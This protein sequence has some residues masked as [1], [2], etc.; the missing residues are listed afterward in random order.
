MEVM[1]A[2][3]TSQSLLKHELIHYFFLPFRSDSA[4]QFNLND[5]KKVAVHLPPAFASVYQE[6]RPTFTADDGDI[7]VD[8]SV[9]IAA[10]RVDDGSMK[11]LTDDDVFPLPNVRRRRQNDDDQAR[12]LSQSAFSRISETLGALNT[13]GSFLVNITRGANGDQHHRGDMH[14]ISSSMLSPAMATTKLPSHS[15]VI[16]E[17]LDE[18]VVISSSTQQSVPDAILTLTKN[19]LG[20][21]MT[22]TIEPLIKRVGSNGNHHSSNVNHHSSSG[23]E[24]LKESK[25]DKQT[26][27]EKIDMAALAEK[28]RKKHQAIHP[29]KETTITPSSTVS[30][31]MSH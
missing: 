21:N 22:K 16:S 28:K 6:H 13:V 7:D 10:R 9:V 5:K 11:Y 31:G 27:S 4:T 2:A 19:V 26:L 25:I 15:A 17:L 3:N 1:P 12:L 20:Q 24:P 29:K 23:K 8:E 18:E 14:L 30:P